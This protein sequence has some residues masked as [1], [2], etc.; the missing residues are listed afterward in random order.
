ME[1]ENE[2]T[3]EVRFRY[4]VL[5]EKLKNMGMSRADLAAKL[6]IE[7]TSV[8][9]YF[10]GERNPNME[11]LMQISAITGLSMD[12]L[13]GIDMENI[14]E[15]KWLEQTG[16]TAEVANAIQEYLSKE[17][18]KYLLQNAKEGKKNSYKRLVTAFFDTKVRGEFGEKP[19]IEVF[20]ENILNLLIFAKWK[21][22]NFMQLFTDNTYKLSGKIN[23]YKTVT[24]S[25]KKNNNENLD[26]KFTG[27]LGKIKDTED[28]ESLKE[29]KH[30]YNDTKE[31]LHSAIDELLDYTLNKEFDNIKPS[32]KLV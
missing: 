18:K 15:Q 31:V 10:T 9:K 1:N 8:D 25:T 17:T 5:D 13:C 12:Y 11:H 22:K 21:D 7:K 23:N 26:F 24:I 29:L 3:Q 16:M 28:L 2:I 19:F 4:E 14:Y 27:I 30:C 20:A 32:Q 6:D